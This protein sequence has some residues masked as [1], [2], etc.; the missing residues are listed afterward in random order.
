MPIPAQVDREHGTGHQTLTDHVVEDRHHVVWGNGLEGQSH[1]AIGSHVGHEGSL[2]LTKSKHLIGH[3][4]PSHL[5]TQDSC[6]S[7]FS[8]PR[9]YACLNSKHTMCFVPGVLVTSTVSL[10]RYPVMLPVPYWMDRAWLLWLKVEDC[11]GSKRLWFSAEKWHFFHLT[12]LLL[13]EK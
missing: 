6:Q 12:V 11:C 5:D 8:R 3:R 7:Q 1:D 4:D 10:A 2:C 13:A 9:R